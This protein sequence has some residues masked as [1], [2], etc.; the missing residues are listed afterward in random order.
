LIGIAFGVRLVVVDIENFV[1]G[2]A[3]KPAGL[4][5]FFRRMTGDIGRMA[6]DDQNLHLLCWIK[7]ACKTPRITAGGPCASQL[8]RIE[9]LVDAGPLVESRRNICQASGEGLFLLR[10][11]SRLLS[12]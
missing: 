7:P 9:R 6:N 10:M 12:L 2:F 8:F 1:V 11:W 4:V 5:A 3:F